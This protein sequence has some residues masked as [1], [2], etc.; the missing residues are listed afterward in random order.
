MK[1]IRALFV[2]MIM[3]ITFCLS[4]CGAMNNEAKEAAREYLADKYGQEVQIVNVRENYKFTGPGGGLLPDG[5]E[6]DKSYNLVAEMDGRQFDVC[7]IQ[8]GSK[9]VGYDNYE[10]AQIRADVIADIE[11]CLSISTEDV[12]LSYSELYGKYGTNLIHDSYSDLSSI[13]ENGKFAIIIATYDSI[14]SDKVTEFASKYSVWDEKS[15]LRME[16]IQYSDV[17]PELSF[18]SFSEVNDPKFALDWYTIWNGSA[19]H[20]EF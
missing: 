11:N 15:I 1:K 19:E 2:T 14:D 13:Y 7:L 16:I 3:I 12:F 4:G 6:S 17:I 10:E 8:D 20:H 9:Y 5:I 18:S